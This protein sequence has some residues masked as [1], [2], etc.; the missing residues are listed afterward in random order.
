MGMWM[1]LFQMVFWA[2]SAVAYLGGGSVASSAATKTAKFTVS[3]RIVESCS[4]VSSGIIATGLENP[5]V[6]C[7]HDT[8]YFLKIS[9]EISPISR[10]KSVNDQKQ[11]VVRYELYY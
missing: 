2:F 10:T 9:N 4:V 6:K 1:R 5:V 8:P 3:L 7:R 11:S